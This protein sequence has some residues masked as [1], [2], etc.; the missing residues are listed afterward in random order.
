[1]AWA[2]TPPPAAAGV[3]SVDEGL[4]LMPP[5]RLAQSLGD[6]GRMAALMAPPE[7]LAAA[8][9]TLGDNVS[10]AAVNS[11]RQAVVSGRAEAVE[12]L[13]AHGR[14]GILTGGWR[15][16]PLFIARRWG[17]SPTTS[18]RRATR[19]ISAR[20]A[21]RI[22]SGLTGS[23]VKDEIAR[24]DHWRRHLTEPIRF[25]DGV[26]TLDQ[27]GYSVFWK[28]APSRALGTWSPLDAQLGRACGSRLRRDRSDWDTLLSSV[29]RLFVQGVKIDWLGFDR[30]FSR[31][32]VVLPTYPFQRQRFWIAG[33][34]ENDRKASSGGRLLRLLEEGKVDQ[35]VEELKAAPGGLSE[36]EL[37]LAPRILQLLAWPRSPSPSGRGTG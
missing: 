8:L 15:S 13:L 29:G 33:D 37:R 18:A 24:A 20:R 7:R 22:V 27:Q 30:G 3:F 16:I 26:A 32:R 5:A 34:A 10:L 1:M 19:S 21:V 9:Q 12:K 25:A 14:Q 2:S 35:I 36:D 6:V 4:F 23:A 17:P 11:P 28:S 31:R